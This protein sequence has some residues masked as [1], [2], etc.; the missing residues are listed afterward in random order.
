[1]ES[2][3][4]PPKLEVDKPEADDD[5]MFSRMTEKQKDQ[6][7]EEIESLTA[8]LVTCSF[9]DSMRA[10][11]EPYAFMTCNASHS[12][13]SAMRLWGCMVEPNFD[14]GPT[15]GHEKEG[16]DAIGPAGTGSGYGNGGEVGDFVRI[17][18][19]SIVE[20]MQAS[21]S[22][23]YKD[24]GDLN[25]LDR[26]MIAMAKSS[27]DTNHGSVESLKDAA[28][29]LVEQMIATTGVSKDVYV[30][31]GDFFDEF[32]EKKI[33]ID[34]K[35]QNTEAVKERA[36]SATEFYGEALNLERKAKLEGTYVSPLLL[37]PVNAPKQQPGVEQK[38][39]EEVME[40]IKA[41]KE[42][43]KGRN[44]D[45]EAMDKVLHHMDMEAKKG[46]FAFLGA[47]ATIDRNFSTCTQKQFDEGI[48]GSLLK[49]FIKADGLFGTVEGE[50]R[51]LSE[52]IRCAPTGQDQTIDDQ[53][54]T[55]L[56]QFAYA[57]HKFG[58]A[59]YHARF[60]V[61]VGL[62]E[63]TRNVYDLI[64]IMDDTF[65]ALGRALYTGRCKIVPARYQC[66]SSIRPSGASPCPDST[67]N[68]GHEM[69]SSL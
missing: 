13:R 37:K 63:Q 48:Q 55:M 19:Q 66:C 69:H 30:T 20:G 53:R 68:L 42:Q 36:R 31:M 12:I 54:T 1:M 22:M 11:A 41:L 51:N 61:D 34:F 17:G 57:R 47:P 64:R 2:D 65:R 10:W 46:S 16:A 59:Q 14:G 3:P 58:E 62:N 29:Q 15:R 23:N 60:M 9:S 33:R 49:H 26:A 39:S 52:F 4:R 8:P 18:G 43:G 24:Q 32:N 40:Q 67:A 35:I 44:E 50:M 38:P 56:H 27:D 28:K 7:R 5:L 45:D 6:A 25:E 21:I